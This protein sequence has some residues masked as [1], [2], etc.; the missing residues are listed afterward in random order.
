M[1]AHVSSLARLL[2][3][4]AVYGFAVGLIRSPRTAWLNMVK[5][6][7]L[8]V[9]SVAVSSLAYYLVARLLAKELHFVAVRRLVLGCYADLSVMLAS[10][11]PVCLF[12]ALVFERPVSSAALGEYPLF[13]GFNVALIALAGSAAVVR[14]SARLLHDHGVRGGRAAAVVG[15]WLGLSLLVGGQ[16]AWYLR[17]FFG[18]AA[19]PEEHGFCLGSQPDFRGDTSF[20]QAVFHLI[21]PPG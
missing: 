1:S 10:L 14:Q 4:P 16:A 17:P 21:V 8:I 15:A 11:A 5:F 13:L 18:N 3:A 12:F 2:L 7:L 19:M 20:Y 9:V 6:P